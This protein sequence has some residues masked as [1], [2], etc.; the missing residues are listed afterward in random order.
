MVVRGRKP[1]FVAPDPA[2]TYR[3]TARA[4]AERERAELRTGKQAEFSL[5]GRPERFRMAL[6]RSESGWVFAVVPEG[7]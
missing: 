2:W 3:Q 7:K 4:F 5:A 1:W 6:V